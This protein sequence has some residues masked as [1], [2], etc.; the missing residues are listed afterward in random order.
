M[1]YVRF[2]HPKNFDHKRKCFAEI[3]FKKSSSDGC[4]SLVERTCVEASE[5][6]LCAHAAKYYPSAVTGDPPIFWIIDE[7]HLPP[8]KEIVQKTSAKGDRCHYNLS[9]VSNNKLGK[10]VAGADPKTMFICED[11]TPRH[12]TEADMDSFPRN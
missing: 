8:D 6:N 7:A 5:L 1:E 9:N 2:L 11:G 12:L 3:A 10:L 4:A